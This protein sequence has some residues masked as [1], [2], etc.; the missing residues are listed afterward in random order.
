[1][2]DKV[3]YSI[4]NT[5]QGNIAVRSTV[6]S[7]NLDHVTEKDIVSFYNHF[8][9]Y[10]AWDTGLLP[11]EGSGILSIRTAGIYTQFAYQHKPGLYHVNWSKSEGSLASAYY[12]AQPYRII[13]CDMKEGNLLGARMF[14]SPYP[15]TTPSQPLY[16][17]NLP[18]TNCKGYRNNGVGW[19][20]L[21]QNEDW[22]HLPLNERIVRFI[23]RCSGVETFNDGNMSETDGPR[24]YRENSKPEY[25]WNPVLWE[26]KSKEGYEWTLDESLW[27]PVL[28]KDKDDQK[29]HYPNG[30]PLTF[31]DALVGDYRAYYYDDQETKPI[32]AIIRPD[33]ELKASDVMG[34]FVNSYVGATS[35]TTHI[36]N[37]TFEASQ[38]VKDEKGST[39]FKGSSLL[40]APANH[41][42]DDDEDEE[43]TFFCESCEGDYHPDEQ[44]IDGYGNYVCSNCLNSNYVYIASNDNHYSL[45]DD[46]I[47]YSEYLSEYFHSS[48]DTVATC[49]CGETYGLSGLGKKISYVINTEDGQKYCV[50]CIEEFAKEIDSPVS[51]CYTCSS[52]FIDAPGYMPGF[53]KTNIVAPYYNFGPDINEEVSYKKEQVTFCSSC[54]SNYFICPCGYVKTSATEMNHSIQSELTLNDSSLN[55]TSCCATCTEVKFA[56]NDPSFSD[57]QIHFNPHNPEYKQY[58]LEIETSGLA[59]TLH[60]NYKDNEP[61]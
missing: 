31:A 56:D 7:F 35:Q 36:L 5:E 32:N 18:N 26:E 58:H 3:N 51:K 55:I 12:L 2:S 6:K 40:N 60:L 49:E 14:Y 29:A 57:P 47:I 16:H 17:V 52:Q 37:N 23:E 9:Q 8:S 43:E 30:N 44:C 33:K 21:Y 20:C 59:T 48:F 61:F 42:H 45:E 22:S 15:I 53:Q 46:S 38:K 10:A 25:L 39:Q 54:A 13:I 27:I 4:V 11:V 1:M 34:Y 19:Q 24:F 50:S 41:N 28:V